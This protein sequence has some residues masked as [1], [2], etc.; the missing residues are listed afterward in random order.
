M[1]L[2]VNSSQPDVWISEKQLRF[3][4]NCALAFGARTIIWACYCAGW[5]Y[6]HVLDKTGAKTQQYEKLRRVNQELHRMGESYMR[7][8]HVDTFFV[9]GFAAEELEKTRKRA[10]EEISTAYFS[11]VHAQGGKL[12][13]G[14]MEPQHG[15]KGEALFI[16]SADDSSAQQDCTYRVTL[17]S[18]AERI[19]LVSTQGSTELTRGEDGSY[20]FEL[21]SCQGALLT[22]E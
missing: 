12:L 11:G 4:A 19:R 1:V 9:G 20:T 16:A 6:N 3:Q 13:V 18:S 8:R 5:W 2:Q 15:G 14:V 17:R 21:A 10:V 22:A 7:Y